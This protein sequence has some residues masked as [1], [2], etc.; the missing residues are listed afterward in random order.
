MVCG[1]NVDIRAKRILAV[2]AGML[3]VAGGFVAYEALE[4]DA[5]VQHSAPPTDAQKTI[6]V[7]TVEQPSP[8][9]D[10]MAALILAAVEDRNSGILAT[11]PASKRL[12]DGDSTVAF[13]ESLARDA[14]ELA[15]RAKRLKNTGFWYVG[16]SS[17]VD[18]RS[19]VVPVDQSYAVA[20]FNELTELRIASKSGPS[21]VPTKYSLDQTAR[22][23]A[24]GD[25]WQLSELGLS[26][27]GSKGLLPSTIVA[28]R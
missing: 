23:V 12:V 18:I 20:H 3:I 14:T 24:T 22:F 6:A 17:I 28:A 5:G 10:R 8:E 2:A 11:P 9:K 25:G 21:D 16:T 19:V 4:P 15:S 7:T 26:D 27:P 13:K 1:G